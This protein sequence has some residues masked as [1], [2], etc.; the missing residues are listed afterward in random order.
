M[1]GVGLEDPVGGVEAH[2]G[3]QGHHHQPHHQPGLVIG[4][5]VVVTSDVEPE[6]YFVTGAGAG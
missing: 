2:G 1:D 3:H 4:N 6:L 5:S